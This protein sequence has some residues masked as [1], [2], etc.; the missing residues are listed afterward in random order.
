MKKTKLI[1]GLIILFFLFLIILDSF[2][3]A[4]RNSKIRKEIIYST[5][6]APE[7][8]GFTIVFISDIHYN[9]FMNQ[10]RF[11]KI[12][13]KINL[14]N[15]DLLIFGGD[16]F[17][18]PKEK[19]P[20][21]Q[22]KQEMIDFLNSINTKYGKYAVYGNHDLESVAAKELFDEIMDKTNFK[23]LNNQ[24]IAVHFKNE[25]FFNLIG[26]D[27]IVYGNIDL[28]KAYDNLD[29]NSFNLAVCHTPDIFDQI[30]HSKTDYLLAGHSHGGQINLFN[31]FSFYK[32][33]GAK[34]YTKGKYYQN[35]STLDISNGVGTTRLDVRF[36]AP[37][38]IVIYKLKSK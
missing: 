31:L 21:N 1:I 30:D 20:D 27:S 3:F 11:K 15:P 14:I 16:L 9:N 2:Y 18:R 4:I 19:L 22:I 23:I 8:D 12:V 24:N 28:N 38:E 37:S 6:I 13:N 33:Q 5:K 35:N 10:T 17:D 29:S 32:P 25:K 36:N 7:L 26:I 34:K